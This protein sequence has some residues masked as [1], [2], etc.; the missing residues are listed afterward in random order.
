LFPRGFFVLGPFAFCFFALGC[1]RGGDAL[2]L[3]LL[4][5]ALRSV[6]Y[7]FFPLSARCRLTPFFGRLSLAFRLFLGYESVLFRL[8]LLPLRLGFAFLALRLFLRVTL[9]DGL[10]LA[11]RCLSGGDAALLTLS[12][13]ACCGLLGRHAL[14]FRFSALFFCLPCTVR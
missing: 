12:A 7:C 10:S 3:D 4:A 11:V 13:L 9:L 8:L 14:Q 5:P 6:R 1:L 2:F